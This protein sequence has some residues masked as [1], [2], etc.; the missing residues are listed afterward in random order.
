MDAEKDGLTDG[1]T[2]LYIA[3]Y[4]GKSAITKQLHGRMPVVCPEMKRGAAIL[5][6]KIDV[7]ARKNELSRD[8]LMPM[9][10]REVERRSPVL[11]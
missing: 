7:R 4:K 9:V 5:H 11:R 6:L 10:G 8:R 2:P 3:A 1:A